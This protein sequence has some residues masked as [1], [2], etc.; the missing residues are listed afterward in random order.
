METLFAMIVSYDKDWQ[1]PV[2]TEKHAFN[3]ATELLGAFEKTVYVGFPW[4]TLI[5][6]SL[7][8]KKDADRLLAELD[9]LGDQINSFSRRVT[10]CQHIHLKRFEHFFKRLGLTDVFWTHA[11]K[12]ETHL[13]QYPDIR[14]YPFPLYPVNILQAHGDPGSRKY[15]Y[16]FIGAR[17]N[18]WYLSNCRSL[19]LNNLS[20]D[21]R[22][23]VKGRDDWHFNKIVY[24]HQIHKKANSPENLM[25]T[26]ATSEFRNVL[27][28]SVFSLCPSGTG[29]NSIRLWESLGRLHHEK[30]KN[31]MEAKKCY[32]KAVSLDKKRTD[33]EK[34]LRVIL[35]E[36]AM[37]GDKKGGGK[38]E[39]AMG[40]EHQKEA[41]E[42]EKRVQHI[43]QF[44]FD[45]LLP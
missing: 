41:A 2:V 3:K 39:D 15:L 44:I 38:I 31:Y 37:V 1:F 33:I 26:D 17:S 11:Q 24:D 22:G 34:R 6:L 18:Q 36:E 13:S 32:S 9:V 42:L 35:A 4:A 12:G 45:I 30:T 7:N 21:N 16:S 25:D 43:E 40:A 8:H 29:S 20:S 10:V 27:A 5:D 28:D 23:M 14:V 19:I